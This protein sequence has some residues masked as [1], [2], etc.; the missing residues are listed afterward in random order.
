MGF[1]G[2]KKHL[3]HRSR[4]DRN[5]H[6]VHVGHRAEGDAQRQHQQPGAHHPQHAV[7]I[8]QRAGQ[9]GEAGGD[10]KGD[11]R[12]AADL[13]GGGVAV[14]TT[15]TEKAD[16]SAASI[17]AR[18]VGRASRLPFALFPAGTPTRFVDARGR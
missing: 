4:S 11:E 16:A 7:A 13:G 14:V 10:G 12:G 15:N 9:R 17:L 18:V 5:A 3:G 8:H 2:D 6:A 1:Q